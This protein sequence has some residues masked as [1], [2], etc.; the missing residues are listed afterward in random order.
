MPED[1]FTT[2]NIVA[3]VESAKKGGSQRPSVKGRATA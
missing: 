1:V 3:L 2:E